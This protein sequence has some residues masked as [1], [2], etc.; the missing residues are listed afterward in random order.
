[1]VVPIDIYRLERSMPRFP[2]GLDP[3]VPTQCFFLTLRVP[4][5]PEDQAPVMAPR[6]QKDLDF[7][8]GS[9]MGN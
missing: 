7:P 9:Q 6:A 3:Q 1:M 4:Q 8:N 5:M 2:Q